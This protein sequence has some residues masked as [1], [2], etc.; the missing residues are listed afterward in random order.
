MDTFP[1][2]K[3]PECRTN[4]SHT[5]LQPPNLFMKKTFA[6]I[7]LQCGFEECGKV[8][9]YDMFGYH[10]DWANIYMSYFTTVVSL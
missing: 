2:K 4:F 7:K 8:V 3:C 6:E 9:T 10:K 5:D 1:Y